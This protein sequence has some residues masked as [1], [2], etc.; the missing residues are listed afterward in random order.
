MTIRK[1]DILEASPEALAWIDGFLAGNEPDFAQFLGV[2]WDDAEKH[3][4]NDD[5]LCE[6]WVAAMRA[7]R[8]RGWLPLEGDDDD[9]E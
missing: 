6:T 4:Y 5:P 9:E 7:F 2:S 1:D 8:T 3:Y